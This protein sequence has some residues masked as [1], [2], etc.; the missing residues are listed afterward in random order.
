MSFSIFAFFAVNFL[1][2]L[3]AAWPRCGISGLPRACALN[4]GDVSGEGHPSLAIVDG[5]GDLLA[6]DIFCMDDGPRILDCLEFDD[7]L[8]HV[9]DARARAVARRSNC[10]ATV[11][12]KCCSSRNA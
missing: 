8:R 6:D 3:V 12:V 5:H 11:N 2:P 1:A 4:A 9:R 7:H 10:F